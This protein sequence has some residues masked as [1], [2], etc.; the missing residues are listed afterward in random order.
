MLALNQTTA[1]AIITLGLLDEPQGNPRHVEEISRVT[2]IPKAY[3]AK[4]VYR[5]R[6]KGF[7]T[8]RRGYRG[9]VTLARPA[10]EIPLLEVAEAMTGRPFSA[11]CLL[12]LRICGDSAT[13]PLNRFWSKTIEQLRNGLMRATLADASDL[14]C[15]ASARRLRDQGIAK[16]SSNLIEDVSRLTPFLPGEEGNDFMEGRS[17]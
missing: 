10:Q 6:L 17:T 14:R 8:T 5:L 16:M 1:Y 3:L 4:L 9:G 11:P 7:V 15:I 2:G 13:C 12:G